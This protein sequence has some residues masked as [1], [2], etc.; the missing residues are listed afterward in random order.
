MNMRTRVGIIEAGPAGLLL[1]LLLR[2]IVGTPAMLIEQIRAYE[3]AGADELVLQWFD[4]DDIDGLRAFAASMLPAL[5]TSP[6]I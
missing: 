5:N 2:A 6:T 1:S 3:N 4:L